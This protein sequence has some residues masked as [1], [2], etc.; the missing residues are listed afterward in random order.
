MILLT[1]D[2][3]LKIRLHA[4][5]KRRRK[6]ER[7]KSLFF[8]AYSWDFYRSK[9]VFVFTVTERTVNISDVG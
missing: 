1:L 6:K 9:W 5:K 2:W 7:K 8:L 3:L 4:V